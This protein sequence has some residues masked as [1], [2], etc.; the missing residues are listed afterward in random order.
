MKLSENKPCEGGGSGMHW[1]GLWGLI[2]DPINIDDGSTDGYIYS[3]ECMKFG[4][5]AFQKVKQLQPVDEP[6]IYYKIWKQER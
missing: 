1:W 6:V 5:N 4:C 3:R 2:S